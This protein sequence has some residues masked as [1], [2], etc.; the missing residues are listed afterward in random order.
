MK[1][2]PEQP[3]HRRWLA[4]IAAVL[5][6]HGG[7]AAAADL[8]VCIDSSSPTA[9]MDTALAHAVARQEGATLRVHS[10]D[11]SGDDDGFALKQFNTL[12]ARSCSLVLG[13]PIDADAHGLPP[14]LLASAPYGHTGFVLVTPS[15]SKATSLAQLPAGSD[16]AVTYQTTPNLYFV[17]H[18]NVNADVHL[19]DAN[20]LKALETHAVGAAMLWRPTVVRFLAERK[21]AARFSVH[22]LNE[23][24]ARFNLVALYDAEHAAQAASFQQAVTALEASGEL[25]RVL[26]P[27][28]QTGAAAPTRHGNSAMLG[29]SGN[30]RI[31]RTCSAERKSAGKGGSKG[32]APPALFTTAQA[33]SGRAKFKEHCAMCHGPNLEGRAG[34]ALKGANFA[35]DSSD[36]NVSDI[37]NILTHN[38]PATE[39]GSLAHVDYVEIMAFLLQQNGYPAGSRQLTFE[40]ATKSRVK[41]RYHGQ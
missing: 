1:N 36:F 13:F 9:S 5:L 31:G 16:V 30:G 35:S 14:G 6:M 33:D 15:R 2:P 8:S 7:L 23:P 3:S 17:D 41:L 12:A 10:F 26:A 39:P 4:A 21:E 27:Y 32:K 38:M 40:D 19:S 29:R 37:F 24:H 22:E 25:A 20:S 18:A 11:G 28:A 34:P